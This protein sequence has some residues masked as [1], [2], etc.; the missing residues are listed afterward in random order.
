ML[1]LSI[2]TVAHLSLTWKRL[3]SKLGLLDEATY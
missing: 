1:Q 3:P 2:L